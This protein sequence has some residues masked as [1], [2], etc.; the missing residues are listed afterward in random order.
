MLWAGWALYWIGSARGVKRAR[1]RESLSSRALH[2]VPL[3]LAATLLAVPAVPGWLGARWLPPS[4][5]TAALG[6][7]LVGAGLALSVYARRVLGGNWSASVTLKEGHEIIAT[8]PYRMI[9]H[10][11]YTGLLAAILGTAVAR[12]EWRGVLAFA[13]SF[14]ALWRKLRLEEHWLGEAFGERYADYRRRTW[15][16]LPYIC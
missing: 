12:G 1:R 15:A 8:G 6:T 11:I 9:R 5:G 4:A 2:V 7:S 13:L 16:L 3:G 14:A 10:P